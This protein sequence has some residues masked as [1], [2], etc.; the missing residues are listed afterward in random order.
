MLVKV[1]KQTSSNHLL[2]ELHAKWDIAFRD[3]VISCEASGTASL[4]YSIFDSARLNPT[5]SVFAAVLLNWII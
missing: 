3:D 1:E 2:S 4:E 5:I